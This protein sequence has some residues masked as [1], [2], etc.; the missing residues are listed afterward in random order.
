LVSQNDAY[1]VDF[2]G[3]PMRDVAE[4]RNKASPYRDVAGILRS[5]HYATATAAERNNLFESETVRSMH[6]D[7]LERFH[8]RVC[9]TFLAAYK[10]SSAQI[11]HRW[12]HAAGQQA[13][14]KLFTL[15][16]AAYEITYEAN[17]RP[18]LLRIPLQGMMDIVRDL[19]IIN[20]RNVH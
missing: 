20:R 18:A 19:D 6:L 7:F 15:E 14:I 2:E 1:F 10:S 16:K 3:E 4:R 5:F 13:L 17:N 12:Q 9:D 8:Q 11:A